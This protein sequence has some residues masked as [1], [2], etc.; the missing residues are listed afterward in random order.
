MKLDRSPSISRLP[1]EPRTLDFEALVT[2]GVAVAQ[3][4]AGDVWTDYNEHDPGVTILQQLCFALTD[5]AY[6]TEHPIADVLLGPTRA[7]SPEERAQA[8]ARQSLYAGDE[9]LTCAPLTVDD[10]RRWLYDQ[11]VGLQNS[12]VL[13]LVEKGTRV[14][15]VYQVFFQRFTAEGVDAEDDGTIARRVEPLLHGERSLG[16]DFA[17]TKPIP[18]MRVRIAGTLDIGSGEAAEDI[19]AQVLYDVQSLLVPPPT[20][21]SLD[22]LL[23]Q[24]IA[25]DAIFDGPKLTHGAVLLASHEWLSR[26]P[27]PS[28]V[29]AAIRNVPGVRAIRDLELV[30]VGASETRDTHYRMAADARSWRRPDA[31]TTASDPE[32]FGAD[33]SGPWI[34]RVEPW[35]DAPNEE[36]SVTRDGVKVLLNRERVASGLRHIRGR[37]RQQ[38]EHF[39]TRLRDQEYL[40]PPAARDRGLSSYRSIQ[41][42]FPAT[43]GIGPDGIPSTDSWFVP[44]EQREAAKAEREARALQLKAYL[45]FF[46]QLLA[47]HLAQLENAHVLFTADRIDEP[48]HT[49]RA[50]DTYFAQS[51]AHHPLREDDPPHVERVLDAALE[52]RR[53]A[54]ERLRDLQRREAALD[55]VLARFGESFDSETVAHVFD[56]A[57]ADAERIAA[58]R[59]TRK[60]TLLRAV[61][62]LG[63]GRGR[64]I[65]YRFGILGPRHW[66]DETSTA[67]HVP[68][69]SPIERRIAA[70]AGLNGPVYVVEHLLLRQ[71]NDPGRRVLYVTHD[72][73]TRLMRLSF[74]LEA[75]EEH[76]AAALEHIGE[77]RLRTALGEEIERRHGRMRL[78]VDAE[79]FVELD[80][81]IETLEDAEAWVLTLRE[82]IRRDR[83][84]VPHDVQPDRLT[85]VYADPGS[86]EARK[87]VRRVARENCPAHLD[88]E[89]VAL[90]RERMH[91][92]ERLYANWAHAWQSDGSRAPDLQDVNGAAAALHELVAPAPR[93]SR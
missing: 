85:L 51:L 92:F 28:A 63:R 5:I 50:L 24:G 66:P 64:G 48:A 46:E 36:L 61:T 52:R 16:Q 58:D 90:D 22:G 84:R 27:S 35:S 34:V 8:A 78:R 18:E 49:T 17:P 38:E 87:F 14:P 55:H 29:V 77:L 75:A 21:M 71:R 74:D 60:R 56:G 30:Q 73:E 83:V 67:V 93:E 62:E 91:A 68:A 88:I 53:S 3:S 43:Y 40:R 7:R 10:I 13:P 86:E 45:L 26:P 41:Y 89:C 31:A 6:R 57:G 20:V 39:S 47:D 59:L 19:V 81:A 42:C 15:N 79:R 37:L 82:H 9:A 25:P 12:W 33:M 65:D 76:L 54:S 32:T 2:E 69:A 44:R 70:F 80:E 1:P 23:E 11:V 4:L 72:D